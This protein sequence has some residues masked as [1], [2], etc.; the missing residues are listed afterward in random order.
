MESYNPTRMEANTHCLCRPGPIPPH[1]L[2]GPSFFEMNSNVPK[3]PRG[4]GL[5]FELCFIVGSTSPKI[6][7]KYIHNLN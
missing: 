7:E 3:S 2:L 4:T 5:V 6:F 1:K